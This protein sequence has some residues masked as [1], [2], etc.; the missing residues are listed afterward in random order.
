MRSCHRYLMAVPVKSFKIV[1]NTTFVEYEESKNPSA[2]SKAKL[3]LEFIKPHGDQAYFSKEIVEALKE[4]GIRATDVM[5]N[6]RG[7]ER[8]GFDYFS[9][10]KH[11]FLSSLVALVFMILKRSILSPSELR[12][13]LETEFKE[14]LEVFRSVTYSSLHTSAT[15]FDA[16]RPDF[17]SI[18][19]AYPDVKVPDYENFLRERNMSFDQGKYYLI[20]AQKFMV[21]EA[22]SRNA[23]SIQEDIFLWGLLAGEIVSYLKSMHHFYSLT[24]AREAPDRKEDESLV[25]NLEELLGVL[26]RIKDTSYIQSPFLRRV[27][28]RLKEM[29]RIEHLLSD[30][31]DY[32][33]TDGT[34]FLRLLWRISQKGLCE[35]KS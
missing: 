15:D 16:S 9:G 12:T 24:L 18:F 13:E 10:K 11:V 25:E 21:V 26:S 23:Q 27:V 34:S 17:P 7:F 20:D 30:I 3:I 31:K 14:L 4:S 2:G 35:V 1:G 8:R 19:L 32:V 22:G 28:T 5:S 6:V 29:N 33:D